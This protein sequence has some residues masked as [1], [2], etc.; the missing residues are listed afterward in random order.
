VP[1]GVLGGL[2]AGYNWQAGPSW[3][4]GFEADLQGANQLQRSCAPTGCSSTNFGN[5]VTESFWRA[6]HKL[7]YFATLRGRVGAVNDNVLYYVTGGAA[8]GHFTQTVTVDRTLS[9]P[10]KAATTADLIGYVV[11]GGIEAALGGGWT[12]KIEY[13]FMDFGSLTTTLNDGTLALST[14]TTIRDHVMRVGTNY[15]F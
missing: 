12:S 10:L 8:F 9:V 14:T 15:R 2:Q 3:L 11:G 7:D 6:E 1:K 4:A 5:S 13:L